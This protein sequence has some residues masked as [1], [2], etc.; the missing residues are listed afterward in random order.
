MKKLIASAIKFYNEDN[1]KWIVMTGIRHANILY[2][3]YTLK[4]KYDKSLCIQGFLTNDGDFVDRYEAKDIAIKA[5][6]IIVPFED[7]YP[8]LFSEDVW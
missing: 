8:E 5:N 2:D 1:G 7:T 3:M 6:Q 4:I